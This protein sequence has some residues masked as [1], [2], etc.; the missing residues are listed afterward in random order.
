MPDRL[1]EYAALYFKPFSDT[2]TPDSA[3]RRHSYVAVCTLAFTCATSCIAVPSI[4]Q[5]YFPTL[6][7]CVIRL[8]HAPDGGSSH[9][10]PR[11]CPQRQPT[12]PVR[13]PRLRRGPDRPVL[14][15]LRAASQHPP[16]VLEAPAIA[17][18][19]ALSLACGQGNRTHLLADTHAPRPH[20]PGVFGPTCD[21]TLRHSCRA[22][23]T[24]QLWWPAPAPPPKNRPWF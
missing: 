16:H 13:L 10:R 4:F 15:P 8:L 22:A 2:P 18:P 24:R 17:R 7:P 19:A 9:R 1:R 20:H 11:K 21:R 12:G 14:R 23:A 3:L 6:F 5:V